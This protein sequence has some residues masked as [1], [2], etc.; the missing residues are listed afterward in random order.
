MDGVLEVRNEHFWT[1][2]F[3]TLVSNVFTV[4]KKK[5]VLLH[6]NKSSKVFLLKKK[7]KKT[8]GLSQCSVSVIY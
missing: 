6:L 3:G 1:L 5:S 7:E 2:G 4:L 8:N